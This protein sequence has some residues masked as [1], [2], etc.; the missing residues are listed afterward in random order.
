MLIFQGVPLKNGGLG[1]EDEA[2]GFLLLG[3]NS[4]LNFG[5]EG[6][7]LGWPKKIR[8]PTRVTSFNTQ[9]FK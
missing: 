1:L 4:L 8:K 6:I 5:G 3:P 2:T 7:P 9:I